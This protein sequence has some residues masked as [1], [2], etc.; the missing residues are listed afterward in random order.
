MAALFQQSSI[1]KSVVWLFLQHGYYVLTLDTKKRMSCY[2]GRR[3]SLLMKCPIVPVLPRQE[4]IQC[5]PEF[6]Q[7]GN[8]KMMKLLLSLFF[9]KCYIQRC[10]YIRR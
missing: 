1:Y 4:S 3:L 7:V 5:D 2:E 6:I 10:L 9:I 8:Q